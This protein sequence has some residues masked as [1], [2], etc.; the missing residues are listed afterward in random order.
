MRVI[1]GCDPNATK[2]K[3][4]LMSFAQKLG[5]EV[6][7]FGS[8][9]PIYANTAIKVAEAVANGE[10]DRGVLLCG[11][12][13]GMSIAANK[14]QG[15]YAALITDD[16]SA[17]RAILSNNSNI[18]CIGAFTIGNMLAQTLLGT[19]LGLEFDPNCRSKDKV[20]RYKEYDKCRS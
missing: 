8:D 14:V 12:G 11:T 6:I 7:D 17:Q 10:G 18:A 13:I 9:D 2:L 3:E 20:D 15:A 4:E 1:F 19:W 5:H 16:Y